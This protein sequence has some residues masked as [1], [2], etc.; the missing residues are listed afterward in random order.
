MILEYRYKMLHNHVD[1][2]NYSLFMILVVTQSQ[3]SI[4]L[5]LF[6]AVPPK[7]FISFNETVALPDSTVRP[8]CSATEGD[9]PFS[10]SWSSPNG[11]SEFTSS[12]SSNIS[13]ATIDIT[14]AGSGY[15]VYTCKGSNSYG[16]SNITFT[17]LQAGMKTL[18]KC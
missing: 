14:P 6:S 1:L 13:D 7:L 8:V 17:I 16:N 11:S 15:G 12:Q 5:C 3:D 10:F 4:V 9:L 18:V 2:K